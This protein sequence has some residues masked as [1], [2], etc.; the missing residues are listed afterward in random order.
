MQ[1]CISN[2]HTTFL[3]LSEAAR[4]GEK[5]FSSPL[6]LHHQQGSYIGSHFKNGSSFSHILSWSTWERLHWK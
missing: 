3:L 4:A 6:V 2:K 5:D 1:S